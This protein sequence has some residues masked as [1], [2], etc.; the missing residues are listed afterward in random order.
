MLQEIEAERLLHKLSPLTDQQWLEVLIKSRKKSATGGIALPGFPPD[1]VQRDSV[2]SAG[3]QALHEAFNFYREIKKYGSDLGNVLTPD[4][5]ILDF[6]CG[7]GRMIRFFLKDVKANNLHG[8]DV[9]PQMIDCCRGLFRYGNFS[10][11]NPLPPTEFP[12]ESFDV[13]YAYSVFSHLAEPV[14]IQWVEEFS[15]IL[16]P[17]GIFVST[18][19]ARHFIEFCRSLHGRTHESG[20]HNSLSRAFLD[21]EAAL[22]DYDNGKFL[23]C[24]TGGGPSLPDSF[25]GEALIPREYIE[26]EWTKYLMLRDFVDDRNRQPQAVIVMQKPDSDLHEY[27]DRLKALMRAKD[28]RI[29]ELET[30]LNE[31]DKEGQ[32]IDTHRHDKDGHFS[33]RES[34]HRERERT[35]NS[36]YQSRGWKLLTIYYKIRDKILRKSDKGVLS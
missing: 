20:W 23:F 13:I 28:A 22:E 25:Y 24:A 16:K 10:I 5:H 34:V 9:N 30:C 8:I 36:I 32:H 2:G 15:R 26:Q 27:S 11:C 31:D 18:T 29:R 19:Q 4:S 6:G 33:S 35:L 12:D 17:G 7:W 21:T 14:H 3:E 1:Q